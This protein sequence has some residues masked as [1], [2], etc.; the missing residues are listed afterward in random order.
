LAELENI[1]GVTLVER[2]RRRVLMTPIGE[3][4]AS[5]A[6]DLIRSAEDMV[7]LAAQSNRA[8]LTGPLRLGI[9]PTI[10]P[11]LLPTALPKVRQAYP[12]LRLHLR[13]D[14]TANLLERLYGGELEAALIALPYAEDGLET[15]SIAHD[16]FVFVC[17]PDH[18]LA[19]QTVITPPQ[20]AAAGLVLLEEGHCLRDHSLAACALAPSAL[21]ETILATSLAT[22]VQMVASGLGVTI[23]PKLAID[24]GVLAGTQLIFRPLAQPSADRI[25]ALCWRNSSVRAAELRLLAPYFSP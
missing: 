25:L 6:L 22:L 4:M 13:E 20:V 7:D 8:P 9:I 10:A 5:R 11:Y 16:P 15:L 2:T 14:L 12:D 18:P 3:Q 1:L 24:N 21:R 19:I 17:R 23:L